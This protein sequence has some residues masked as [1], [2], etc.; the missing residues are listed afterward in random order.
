MKSNAN[1]YINAEIFHDYIR[2][3]LLPTLPQLRA[4]DIFVEE[5]VMLLMNN[6]LNH[7]I[8]VMI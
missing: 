8:N 3:V 4:L 2:A 1:P 5:I 7:I 6:C